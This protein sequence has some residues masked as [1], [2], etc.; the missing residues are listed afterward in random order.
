MTEP[1]AGPRIARFEAAPPEWRGGVVAIG[2]FD[3]VHLGHQA[4]LEAARTEGT[5]L[6]APAIALT[7]EPHPRSFFVPERPLFRLTPAPLKAAL[8]AA[9]GLRGML[10]LPFDASLARTEAESFVQEVLIGRLA[11]RHA[12]VGFDFHFGH[13]RRGTPSFLQHAGLAS[14]FS[15]TVVRE[16]DADGEAVSSTRVR[17]ALEKGDLAAANRLLGWTW[18]M[19]GEVVHGEARGRTLGFPTAN[20]TPEPACGLRHGIYAA[21]FTRADG[22]VHDG[23]ASFGRRPTFDHGRPLLETF[24]FAFDG[25]L[26]GET[27]LVSLVG[28]IRGEERFASAQALTARMK[29]DAEAARRILAATPPGPLDRKVAALWGPIHLQAAEAGL[30]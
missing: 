24:L 20:M 3:G 25:D 11:L 12:V 15:V 9:V 5:H 27:A 1:G 4:V 8:A 10:V 17:E 21:R 16:I 22:T 6:R 2:N 19:S 29:E 7:F 28:W 23:V 18:S 26:Y 13:Q 14:G 30:A